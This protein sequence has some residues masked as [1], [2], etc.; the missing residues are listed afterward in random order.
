MIDYDDMCK[1]V[2]EIAEIGEYIDY[3]YIF[4]GDNI[5]LTIYNRGIKI[6]TVFDRS[7]MPIDEFKRSVYKII[8]Y[9]QIVKTIIDDKLKY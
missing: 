6:S 5:K 4:P 7:N 1:Y 3:S 2:K 9:Y 8:K